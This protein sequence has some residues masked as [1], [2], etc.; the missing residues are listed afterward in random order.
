[1]SSEA[2][3]NMAQSTKSMS[4]VYSV[5]EMSEKNF[6]SLKQQVLD[7]IDCVEKLN[8]KEQEN[9]KSVDN[10]SSS[11]DKLL[12]SSGQIKSMIEMFRT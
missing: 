8:D 6:I 12:Q 5:V 4:E 7:V 3:S 11:I 1:M 10:M 9:K 2:R